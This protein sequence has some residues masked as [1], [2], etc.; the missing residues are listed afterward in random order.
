MR[1]S[2]YPPQVERII[3]K[4]QGSLSAIEIQDM[5]GLL[6]RKYVREAFVQPAI[7]LDLI[8]MT[9]PDKP[10]SKNQKYKLTSLGKK[11][12]QELKKH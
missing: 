10:R 5:L 1:P 6:D 8:E 2:S 3:L 4:F 7:A 11:F 12:Q 9:L